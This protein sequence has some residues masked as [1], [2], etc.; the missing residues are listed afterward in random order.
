MQL[1]GENTM[2]MSRGAQL[3]QDIRQKIQELKQ[4]SRGVDENLAS[5]APENRWSP[6]QIL[7]HLSG[8]EGAGHVPILR[9]ILD[10]DIPTIDLETENPFFSESRA[11][12]SFGELLAE[13]VKDYERV[14]DLAAGLSEEQLKRTAHIPKLKDSPLGEYPTLEAVIIGLCEYHVQFHIDHLREILGALAAQ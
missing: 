3:A 4:I 5:R 13:C 7:S 6:K 12:M 8:P 2:A 1:R 9:A 10:S 14:A 11:R